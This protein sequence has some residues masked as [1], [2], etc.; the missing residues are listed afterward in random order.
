MKQCKSIA[1]NMIKKQNK[2]LK[3]LQNGQLIKGQKQHTRKERHIELRE[4]G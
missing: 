4:N 1:I 2:K 3:C